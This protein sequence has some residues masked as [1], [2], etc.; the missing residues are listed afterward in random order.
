[1]STS[2]GIHTREWTATFGGASV[3]FTELTY[4]ISHTPSETTASHSGQFTEVH[5]E[6]GSSTLT[7][8]VT[9]VARSNSWLKSASATGS[10]IYALTAECTADDAGTSGSQIT[11]DFFMSG[12][13]QGGGTTELMTFSATLQ[14]S[15]A[16]TF[17]D[18]VA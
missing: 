10:Q 4:S 7:I 18:P 2:A 16:W 12:L 1:M 13:E 17:T 15:G 9:G 6:P 3:I 5:A 11:G 14:S 8:S